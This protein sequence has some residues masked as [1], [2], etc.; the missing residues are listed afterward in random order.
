MG[1]DCIFRYRPYKLDSGFWYA[2][3]DRAVPDKVY[4]TRIRQNSIRKTIIVLY[5]VYRAFFVR[6]VF[7][8]GIYIYKTDFELLQDKSVYYAL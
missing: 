4:T 3:S 1:M 8:H 2:A 7:A 6:F 5:A